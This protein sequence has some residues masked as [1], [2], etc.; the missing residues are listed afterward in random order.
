LYKSYTIEFEDHDELI[1]M[2]IL[3][4]FAVKVKSSRKKAAP[5]V[6]DKA[7][8]KTEYAPKTV[9]HFLEVSKTLSAWSEEDIK[10]LEENH[11][12]FNEHHIRAKTLF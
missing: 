2:E 3:K 1:L 11:I 4:R 10:R 9:G 7:I 5:K 6:I 8:A 12:L